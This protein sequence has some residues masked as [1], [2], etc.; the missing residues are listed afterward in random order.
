MATLPPRPF[1]TPVTRPALGPT[2]QSVKW[3]LVAFSPGLVRT[4]HE[5][6]QSPASSAEVK[7]RMLLHLHD[8]IRLHDVVLNT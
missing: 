3:I 5:A 1:V 7:K 4:E 6:D 8:L 2:Q